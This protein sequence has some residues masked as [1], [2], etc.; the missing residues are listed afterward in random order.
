MPSVRQVRSGRHEDEDEDGDDRVTRPQ[1]GHGS[2]LMLNGGGYAGANSL[3]RSGQEE[4]KEVENW[5]W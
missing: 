1:L 4:V 3:Q 2:V 5:R